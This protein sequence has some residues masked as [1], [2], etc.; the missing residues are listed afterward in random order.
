LSVF[1][2][3]AGLVVASVFLFEVMAPVPIPM[4]IDR[5]RASS[6]S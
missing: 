3:V 1:V 2:L 4:A 5:P 6:L